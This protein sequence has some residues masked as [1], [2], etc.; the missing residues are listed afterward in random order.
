MAVCD[1]L[2]SVDIGPES[3]HAQRSATFTPCNQATAG[4]R[5]VVEGMM[6]MTGR[7][8]KQRRRTVLTCKTTA[9]SIVCEVVTPL[10]RATTWLATV[11][12]SISMSASTHR[13]PLHPHKHSYVLW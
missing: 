10:T 4:V 12:D 2:A 5:G 7:G 11:E 8:G 9:I 3:E 1:A 13:G 6:K